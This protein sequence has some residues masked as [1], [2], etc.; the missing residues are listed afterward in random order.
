MGADV[1]DAEPV[2]RRVFAEVDEA[3]GFPL[4]RLCFEGPEE[5]LALTEHA[6]PAILAL[7]VA[8]FR[9]LEQRHPFTPVVVAGHSLGEWTALV[10]AGGLPL[11][12]AARCVRER[13]R[14]MQAAVPVGVGA[15]AAVLGLDDESVT[16]LCAEVAGGDVL[17]PANL[18]GA[19][20]V[21][22]AGHAAAVDRLVP[23]VAARG[24]RA[25]RLK[26]SA[27][28]H[29]PLMK[30][31]AVGLEAILAGVPTPTTLRHVVVSSVD[32][33]P[34]AP[35]AIKSTLVAQVTA[36]VRWE[37]TV[38]TLATYQPACVLEIGPGR[39]LT[40]LIKRIAPDLPVHATADAAGLAA[41]AQVLA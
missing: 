28:F 21:V 24:G 36:P 14:L 27:P 6:Q 32:A 38:R 33:R 18:N 5:T 13:G 1:V 2:A 41:A 17:C 16:T 9:V 30:P 39:V 19:G 4:S 34:M 31:A 25:Q 10:V 37:A 7:S 40:G 20:Q 8:F 35:A 11:A 23:L 12:D 3:L 26:V 22:V 15:M 29:C